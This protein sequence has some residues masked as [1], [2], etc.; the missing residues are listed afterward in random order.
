MQTDAFAE[1]VALTIKSA[2][3]PVLARL[4]AA[5]ARFFRALCGTNQAVGVANHEMVKQNSPGL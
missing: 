4:S 5:D 2:L 1:L 3:G